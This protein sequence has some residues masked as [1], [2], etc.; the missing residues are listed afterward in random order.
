MGLNEPELRP[1]LRPL[2]DQHFVRRGNRREAGANIE[3]GNTA[4]CRCWQYHFHSD[5]RAGSEHGR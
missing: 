4:A 1:E 5:P 3:P 2:H